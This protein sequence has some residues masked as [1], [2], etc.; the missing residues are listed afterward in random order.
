MKAKYWTTYPPH[1]HRKTEKVVIQANSIE[2]DLNMALLLRLVLNE[3]T[4]RKQIDKKKIG[5]QHRQSERTV[6]QA[7]SLCNEDTSE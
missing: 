1:L 4:R 6:S 7:E 2:V 3:S 5:P